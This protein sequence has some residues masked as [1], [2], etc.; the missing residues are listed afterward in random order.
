[1]QMADGFLKTPLLSLPPIEEN[2][3]P[4]KDDRSQSSYKPNMS[5][6]SGSTNKD[7]LALN[8]DKAKSYDP[9][10]KPIICD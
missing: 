7:F 2:P 8:K 6:M 10:K 4:S 3:S 5:V 1:M 9:Y